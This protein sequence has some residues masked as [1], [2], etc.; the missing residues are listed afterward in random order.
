MEI[1]ANTQRLPFTRAPVPVEVRGGSDAQEL[2]SICIVQELQPLQRCS[3]NP[4]ARTGKHVAV[5]RV[6]FVH[7]C[8]VSL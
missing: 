5:H 1:N 7:S 4:R 8:L 2:H 3:A 6:M